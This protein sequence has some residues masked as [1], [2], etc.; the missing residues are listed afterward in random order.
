[1]RA[2]F[3]GTLCFLAALGVPPRAQGQVVLDSGTVV[4]LHWT[5]TSQKARL[6]APL[7]PESSHIRFCLYPSPVCGPATSNP[8]LARPV[9]E[10]VRIEVRRGSRAGR[11]ALIGAGVAALGSFIVLVGYSE[12]PAA[13]TGQQVLSFALITAVWSGFGALVGA[14]SDD[15][16]PVPR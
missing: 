7:G 11:G 13:S 2:W 9:N 3:T 12:R 10:L 15:W 8:P 1:M 16:K 14:A 5:Q 6:L 4:R